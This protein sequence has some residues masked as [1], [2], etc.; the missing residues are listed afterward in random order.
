MAKKK[1][2]RFIRVRGRVI[3][4]G[5]KREVASAKEI[6]S[7][8][9]RRDLAK[10]ASGVSIGLGGSFLTGKLERKTSALSRIGK[11]KSSSRI[12]LLAKVL[13]FT[14]PVVAG[15]MAVSALRSIDRR[16]KDEKARVFN[17]GSGT[18]TVIGGAAALAGGFA[19]YRFGK[20][21]QY[22]GK[23]GINP[24]L[25]KNFKKLRSIPDV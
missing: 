6:L 14:A 11:F 25:R 4:V 18:K 5:V 9:N 20:L 23:K 19:F 22:A 12:H 24:L 1:N 3:P 16:S 21:F 2:V 10:V 15:S 7:R 17:I 13:K 8:K